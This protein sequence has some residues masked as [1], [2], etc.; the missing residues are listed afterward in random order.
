MRL[1]SIS[2]AVMAS[3]SLLTLMFV[4]VTASQAA[5][6]CAATVQP[7]GDIQAAL[8]TAPASSTICVSSGT[9]TISAT[10]LPKFRQTILGLSKSSMPLIL[11]P[12]PII[13]CIDGSLGPE[14]VRLT[15]LVFDGARAADIRTGN[16][17]KLTEIEARNAGVGGSTSGVGIV[18]NGSKVA[19][20]HSYVHDNWQFGIRAV[21]A[22]NLTVKQTEVAFNPTDPAATAGFSGGVK[23]NGVVGL[24][25]M[26][27]YVHDNGGGAG[28]WLDVDSQ[29]FQLVSNKV[30]NNAKDEIR[31][32][33]SCFGSLASNSVTGGSNAGIDLFNAHDVT[34]STNVV[35]SPAAAL[36]GVRM[37]NN[38]RTATVG[39]GACL[40]DGAYQ[41]VNNQAVSNSITMV[42]PATIVGIDSN[43]G[44]A[45]NN[46]W[47]GDVFA[48]PDCNGLQWQWWDG[49]TD[50]HVNFL[51]WQTFG[52]DPT[53]S[54]TSTSPPPPV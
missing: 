54:C 43:G 11:C 39:T 42:D 28:I 4:P 22:T 40:I 33:T 14:K 7:G 23:V 49:F 15:R 41:N 35:T 29:N 38:G 19:I 32:E 36:F 6:T 31:V 26:K 25:A 44:I 48:V 51:G 34:V 30:L 3:V 37:L 5:A 27:N 12:P 21:N 47:A 45:S 17:W 9:Y 46:T 2:R 1:A 16:G 53:G 24:I 10:L 50:Q 20:T 18:V 13:F 8:D 52:Q